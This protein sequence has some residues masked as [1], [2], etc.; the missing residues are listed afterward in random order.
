MAD[1]GSVTSSKLRLLI[2]KQKDSEYW[3]PTMT[4]IQVYRNQ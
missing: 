1:F 4:E 3:T 2:T